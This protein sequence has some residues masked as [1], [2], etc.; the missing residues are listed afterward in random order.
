MEEKEKKAA[1]IVG[2]ALLLGAAAYSKL[3]KPKTS[4]PVPGSL[5]GTE[6][7][8]Q[9]VLT[10][11]ESGGLAGSSVRTEKNTAALYHVWVGIGWDTRWTTPETA[12]RLNLSLKLAPEG[13]YIAATQSGFVIIRTTT[14]EEEEAEQQYIDNYLAEK[15]EKQEEAEQMAREQ[16]ATPKIKLKC[17][18]WVYVGPKQLTPE[19]LRFSFGQV[20]GIEITTY[21]GTLQRPG[22]SD[23][24]WNFMSYRN[25]DNTPPGQWVIVAFRFNMD[26]T[27]LPLGRRSKLFYPFAFKGGRA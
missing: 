23:G 21:K 5:G 6:T 20:S 17:D 1:L 24:S 14:E 2:G 3:G 7:V 8:E 13:S 10:E 9:V 18:K 22:N 4:E 16:Q 12:E 19:D 26:D 25:A 15:Q 11:P 27:G